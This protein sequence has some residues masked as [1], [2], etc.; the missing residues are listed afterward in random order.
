MKSY[1][2]PLHPDEKPPRSVLRYLGGKW[3]I[4]PWVISHLPPHRIYVEPFGGAASVLLRKP[5]SPVEVYNDLDEEIAGIFTVIQDPAQCQALMRRLRRVPY[6]RVAFEQS[7]CP[8]R[9][10]VVRAQRAI[11]RAYLAFHHGSLFDLRKHTFA[12]ARHRTGHAKSH[13]WA[14]YPRTLAFVHRRLQGVVIERRDAIDVIR[15]QDTPDTLFYVD[16][17]YVP[18]TRSDT[19]YRC[20]LT[21]EHHAELLDRL[22]AV[23]GMVVLSGYPSA[24]YDRVLAG[25]QRAELPTRAAG[26]SR[27]RREVLWLS[28]SASKALASCNGDN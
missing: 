8:S 14:S 25:W 21:E 19:S 28:P 2:I 7:F 5:R 1:P 6:G 22:R 24:L 26:S 20:E 23:K 13:E 9:D 11:T 17:P 27:P 15:A 3:R 4:A 18:S 10:S 12:D 16:P